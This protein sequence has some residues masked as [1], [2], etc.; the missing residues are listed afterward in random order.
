[1]FSHP[2]LLQLKV[3]GTATFCVYSGNILPN[4]TWLCPQC[5]PA[6]AWNLYSQ[7]AQIQMASKHTDNEA[8]NVI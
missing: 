7:S 6:T 2:V 1:M 4:V 3:N 8:M 5:A